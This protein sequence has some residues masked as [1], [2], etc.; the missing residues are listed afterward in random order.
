VV[1]LVGPL[2]TVGVETVSAVIVTDNPEDQP[3]TIEVSAAQRA[4]PDSVSACG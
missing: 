2:G 1:P 4:E 3:D